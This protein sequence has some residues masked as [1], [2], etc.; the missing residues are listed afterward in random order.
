MDKIIV[1]FNELNFRKNWDV[2]WFNEFIKEIYNNFDAIYIN[3]NDY[4]NNIFIEKYGK[5]PDFIIGYEV[6][7]F[8]KNKSK[9][10]LITEDLHLRSLEIYDKLFSEVDFILPR[11]NII[12][13]LFNNKFDNKI[14]DFPLYCNNLFLTDKINFESKKKIVMYG[15]INGEQYWLRRKW[16]NYLNNKHK[17]I[18]NFIHGNTIYTSNEIKNYS[19]GLVVGYTPLLFEDINKNVNG[20][21]VAKYFEV[22]GSGL[23]LLAD[24]TDMIENFQKYGFKDNI[25]YINVNFKNI[26]DKINFIFDPNNNKKIEEIRQNGYKLVKEKH[27]IENRIDTLK[28]ILK[29][30][31]LN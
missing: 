16:F 9:K 12:N 11:F 20:Y 30:I 31:N 15:N 26:D 27:L 4:D 6:F 3:P 10:I 17:E 29:P 2:R 19:F 8:P 13:N 24:T 21:V 22:L 1:I 25:N 18:F 7:L 23:L 28:K 5:E 14:I